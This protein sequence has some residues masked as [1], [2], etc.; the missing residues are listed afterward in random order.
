MEKKN[1]VPGKKVMAFEEFVHFKFHLVSFHTDMHSALNPI[2]GKE[3][4]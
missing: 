4:D 3:E 2:H 1:F